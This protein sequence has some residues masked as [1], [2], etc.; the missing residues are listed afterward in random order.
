MIVIDIDI[1]SVLVV[2][3]LHALVPVIVSAFVVLV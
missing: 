3:I 2:V 1:V